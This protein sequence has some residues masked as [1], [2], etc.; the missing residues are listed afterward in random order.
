MKQIGYC[1]IYL[2]LLAYSLSVHAQ[3]PA[4]LELKIMKTD[5]LLVKPGGSITALNDDGLIDLPYKGHA[6]QLKIENNGTTAKKLVIANTLLSTD[7]IVILNFADTFAVE[8]DAIKVG[9]DQLKFAD[10]FTISWYDAQGKAIDIYTINYTGKDDEDTT[11]KGI[12]QKEEGSG[13]AIY[14]AYYLRYGTKPRVR[15]AILAYYAGCAT[16]VDSVKA[17]YKDNKFVTAELKAIAIANAQSSGSKKSLTSL[18]TS[19]GGLDVTTFADGLAQFL[20]KRTKDELNIAFFDSFRTLIQKE[21]YKDLQTIFPETYR[22]LQIVGDE[23]YNFER[24]IETLRES[25]KNDLASLTTNLPTIIDNH[26]EFFEQHP[27]LEATLLTGTY[28]AEG[29][30]DKVHPGQLLDEY[31]TEYLDN[32]P[33]PLKGGIQTLQLFSFSLRDSSRSDSTYWVSRAELRKTVKDTAVFRIYIGLVRQMAISK[34]DS[35]PFDADNSL[36][37]LLDAVGPKNLQ[38]YQAYVFGLIEK[39]NRLDQMIRTYKKPASD[40]LAFEQYY[41]Y[42]RAST[43]LL[44]YSL[45]AAKLPYMPPSVKKLPDLARDY[46]DVVNTTSD[47]VLAINRKN[48]PTAITHAVHIYDVIRVRR[49][50]KQEELIAAAIDSVGKLAKTESDATRKVALL[51]KVDTLKTLKKVE[52]NIPE[53]LGKLLKYGSFMAGVAKAKTS[54]EVHAAI[55]A[56]AL[57]TGSSRIKRESCFNVSLNA[58]LGGYYGWEKIR[59]VDEERQK[60][61][62]LTA[63]VGIAISKGWKIGNGGMST[64]LFISIID[65][66]AVASFRYGTNTYADTTQNQTTTVYELPSIQLKDIISPGTFLSI[67]IPKTPLSVNMG[68]QI[69]PN[70]RKVRLDTTSGTPVNDLSDRMYWRFSFSVLVDIP[71]LNFYTKSRK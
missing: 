26:P 56:F 5:T 7:S 39:T 59:G 23:I 33:T 22:T 69:G 1:L 68:A 14:D 27:E 31:P 21:E 70:L 20:I 35:I 6:W 62:G 40:S 34:Y 60:S 8:N 29:I 49:S 9:S 17:A 71:I 66:G 41:N 63:P 2:S 36:V 64:S 16:H 18:L 46:F 53:V 54:E 30:R 3:K 19:V 4:V 44:E 28:L 57:P 43:D 52:S 24:Y 15:L 47:L 50:K 51:A 42:F 38:K 10:N 58:Y 55:E 48:Y 13:A 65:I 11:D 45:S 32:L 37:S 67:G 61:Y 25:F 12:A